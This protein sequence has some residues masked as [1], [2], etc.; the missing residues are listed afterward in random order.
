LDSRSGQSLNVVD[1][2]IH[3]AGRPMSTFM[4]IAPALGSLKPHSAVRQGFKCAGHRHACN[5]P[6]IES[7]TLHATQRASH[8]VVDPIGIVSKGTTTEAHD[9]HRGIGVLR[10]VDCS[11]Q[12]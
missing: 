9:E 12:T 1:F 2:Y 8:G 4:I 3:H 7:V 10:V 6:N 5:D 11:R